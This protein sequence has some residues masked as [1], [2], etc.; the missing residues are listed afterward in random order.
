MRWVFGTLLA[1][2]LLLRVD[3]AEGA[4]VDTL[5]VMT[6]NVWVAEGSQSGRSKLAEIMAAANADVIG[7]QEMDANAGRAVASTLGFNY[8]QQ[9]GS[10]IQVISRYPIVGNSAGK[11]GVR[12]QLSP[13]QEVWLF[14]A[15]LAAYP[16][17][18]YDLRDGTLA[19]NEAA[20]IAA[21]NAIRGG[22]VTS[23]LSDMAPALASGLPVFF[24]GD[25]NEPSHLDWTAA[26]AAATPRPYDL[27]VEYPTSK[28]IVDA[29]LTDSL[30]AVRPDPVGD[31]AYTWTPGAPPPA[32]AADEVHDRIDIVYHKGRGVTP[33]SAMTVGYPDG[34]PN[35]DLSVPGYNADHRSVVVAYHLPPAMIAGDLNADGVLDAADWGLLRDHQLADLTGLT[36]DQAFQQGDLNGDFRNDHADFVVFKQYFEAT[37]GVG[38]FAT[39]LASVP[40]PP[41]GVLLAI[42]AIFL[43]SR[44]KKQT[45]CAE[46]HGRSRQRQRQ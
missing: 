8:Y 37:N 28:R 6:F 19:K 9:S 17:Q 14:N 33:L 10:D 31:P 3:A 34:N 2:M 46:K 42:A 7:V 21:A 32:V 41:G 16:Y 11:Q 27:K 36:S 38:A 30:R 25:F 4:P 1:G 35:T 44:T 39:M 15:H 13:G 12:I 22:Q 43:S 26:A 23:Y 45:P 40:E 24:T 18:P 5:R 29:G 20:V